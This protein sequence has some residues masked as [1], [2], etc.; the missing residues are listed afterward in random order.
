MNFNNNKAI[1]PYTNLN[2]FIQLMYL[3]TI[4]SNNIIF[5]NGDIDNLKDL[6]HSDVRMEYEKIYHVPFFFYK[7][8]I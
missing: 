6:L 5:T 8:E 7:K 2:V 3:D 4:N 1:I